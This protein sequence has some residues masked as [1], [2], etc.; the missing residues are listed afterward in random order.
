MKHTYPLRLFGLAACLLLLGAALAPAAEATPTSFGLDTGFG[1]RGRL[2]FTQSPS[3]QPGTAAVADRAGRLLAAVPERGIGR[4][5]LIRLLPD[6]SLDRGFAATSKPAV[7]AIAVDSRN[8]VLVSIGHTQILRLA[9]YLPSGSLDRGFGESGTASMLFL[10]STRGSGTAILP[11][12]IRRNSRA[13]LNRLTADGRL[14]R[15]FGDDGTLTVVLPAIGSQLNAIA[16]DRRGDV[17][18]AGRELHGYGN[19]NR[20]YNSFLLG[21]LIPSGSLDPDFGDGGWLST[22]F[23]TGSSSAAS[24]LGLLP[25]GRVLLAGSAT[26]PSLGNTQGV[27]LA[28][29]RFRPGFDR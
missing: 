16:I 7:E 14:D 9:R 19:P 26:I 3:W 23:G 18:L 27:V 21:R 4:Q 5:D 28:R 1:D 13:S 17:Y 29:Y 8:R 10:S 22:R 15:S 12:S 20:S 6:G 25:G 2:L 11:S 24:D